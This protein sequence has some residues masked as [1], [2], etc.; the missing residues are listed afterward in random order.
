MTNK[1]SQTF[2]DFHQEYSITFPSPLTH[3]VK[4]MSLNMGSTIPK[5][6]L[7]MTF[8]NVQDNKT[9]NIWYLF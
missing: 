6:Y 2:C 3:Y 9:I 4:E 8:K 5:S 7:A 1:Y